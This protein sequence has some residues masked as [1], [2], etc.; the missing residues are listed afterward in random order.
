MVDAQRWD[1]LYKRLTGGET[2]IVTPIRD[3]ERFILAQAYE[4][5][6]DEQGR[7]VIPEKLGEYSKL[8]EDVYFV[9]LGDRV[10]IWSKTLWEA[11]E[12]EIVNKAAEFIEQLSNKN[13]K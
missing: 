12:K 13:G 2:L 3:T 1:A 5:S 7:I 8:G 4:V 10:E 6:P 11:R 9:G